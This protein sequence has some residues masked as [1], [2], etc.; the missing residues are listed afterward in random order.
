MTTDIF[1]RNPNMEL[2]QLRRFLMVVK[3][4]SLAAAAPELGLTQQALGAGI[5]KLE[6]E[7]GVLL[8]DRGP[9]GATA[10]TPY[11]TLLIRH[12]KHIL[13]A[14]DRARE[15]LVAFRDARGGS[16]AIGI[17][18]AFASEV[19]ADAVRD[20]HEARPEIRISI[21]EDYSE[22][23]L[24]RLSEGDIDF[25]AGA[26]TGAQGND[27]ERFPLYT[28]HDIV[29]ARAGHPLAR[30]RKITLQDMQPY[31]WMVPRARPMDQAMIAEAFRKQNLEPPARLIWT[32]ARQA[33]MHLLLSDDFLL[34]TSPAMVTDTLRRKMLVALNTKVPTV[35][36]R[37]G[38]IYRTDTKLNPSALLLM[39]DIRHKVHL[40]ID[41]LSYASPLNP[42]RSVN[43]AA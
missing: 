38:L 10:V 14:A 37:A 32:D 41:E 13:A 25:I 30:R 5:A 7:M 23:L 4:G 27:L 35:E 17:G 12:A 29:V 11:G 16:V 33:G 36:R 15:E 28:S 18:E 2:K 26:D 39:D 22:V 9:G 21:I 40:H 20:C 24:D 1:Q 42:G 43:D 31:T 3:R 19:I 8:F 34:M 6:E